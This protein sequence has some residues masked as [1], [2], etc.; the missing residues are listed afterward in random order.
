MILARRVQ[1]CVL[2]DQTER[3]AGNR[4]TALQRRLV[5]EQKNEHRQVSSVRRRRSLNIKQSV[6]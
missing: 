2:R 3:D 6:V 5:T 1:W 4:R